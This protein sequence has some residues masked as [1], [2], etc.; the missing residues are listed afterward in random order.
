MASPNSSNGAGTGT[1]GAVDVPDPRRRY[2]RRRPDRIRPWET[3]SRADLVR[4]AGY[5]RPHRGRAV[6][7]LGCA[8]VGALLALVP[9]FVLR[10]VVD[11]LQSGKTSFS[12][13]GVLVALGLVTVIGSGLLN[14]AQSYESVTI[15][16]S[17]VATLRMELFEHL[18]G[19][20][21]GFFS[22]RRAGDLMS[23][24]LNDVGRID[25]MISTTF[26]AMVTSALSVAASLAVMF[27][28]SWQLT[29]VT[30]MIFPVV[31]VAVRL[32]SRNV[33]HRSNLVQAQFADITAY[34]HELLGPAAAMVVKSFGR[35]RYEKAR[36]AEANEQM[37]RLEIDSGMAGRW[38]GLVISTLRIAGPTAI[39][40]V[41][42]LLVIHHVVT[43]GTLVGFAVVGA[44]GFGMGLQGLAAA[45]LSATATLPMWRRIFDVLDEPSDV[46]DSPTAVALSRVRG[47]VALEGV[48]FAYQSGHRAALRDVSLRI[49]PGQLVALVGPSGAGKTTLSSLVARFYDPQQG[50][51]TMDGTDLRDITLASVSSA[52]G[53]VLQDTFLFHASLR[54][55][56]LYGRPDATELE[57]ASAVRDAALDTVV[58]ALPDGY[59][60][61][62]GD[63]G[64][65][66]SGG[67]RQRVAIA[68]AILKDPAILVLDEA[69]SH[70]DSISED[71]IQRALASLFVGRT[72]LVIAHR[73]STIRTAD[74]IVVLNEG[75]IVEQ[76][77]HDHL[78][79]D[80]GLYTQLYRTQFTPVP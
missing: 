56:L 54:E 58:S 31:A 10:A 27:L 41:G 80:G 15:G 2:R 53:L 64:H 23:R 24:V 28:F 49:E 44:V 34:L 21:V 77:D 59:D 67:E 76:G 60:T 29:L 35:E 12:R 63:R 25:G 8:A 36:F 43:L 20:S 1:N 22:R 70:L 72:A 52:V 47:E 78:S 26:F 5:L 32:A 66:L 7:A 19:Q 68:R 79:R 9:A 75:R 57:L 51:V 37:R 61:V 50:R 3:V 39:L 33:Y 65:R 18:L 17:I 55:N 74:L 73:L 62:I 48:T 4:I 13:I 16:K 40:L 69:T 42:S 30:V 46:T 14:V 6:V 45:V 38:A 11:D 71:L